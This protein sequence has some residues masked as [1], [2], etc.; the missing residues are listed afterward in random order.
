[1]SQA[2]TKLR[3][4]ELLLTAILAA[5]FGCQV[6]SPRSATKDNTSSPTISPSE[7]S[8]AVSSIE[9]LGFELLQQ[10]KPSSTGNKFISPL[11][12]Q[13]A[14]SMLA[15]GT[16]GNTLDQLQ[17]V[18]GTDSIASLTVSNQ[19]LTS[20]LRN[21]AT[22]FQLKIANAVWTSNVAQILPDYQDLLLN[23]YRAQSSSLDFSD[24]NS[25]DE[26]NNWAVT[27]TNGK[28]KKIVDH[29]DP[30]TRLILANATYFKAEW[31]R[32]FSANATA[33]ETFTSSSGQKSQ[34]PFLR[35]TTAH[36]Y[37]RGEGFQAIMRR[38]GK[39]ATAA[40]IAVRPDGDLDQFVK[41]LDSQKWESLASKLNQS[42]STYGVFKM[43]KVRIEYSADLIPNLQALGVSDAFTNS[44]NFS[45]MST[46]QLA[47]N[48]LTHKTF[49]AVDEQGTEA[50]AVTTGAVGAGIAPRIEYNMV[51]DKPYLF[52]IVHIQTGAVLFL[53]T[54]ELPEGGSMPQSNN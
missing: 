36:N 8:V 5:S 28:I 16:D 23:N 4:T 11:S 50:A 6:Q 1:M 42:T 46:E 37:I 38:Y 41:S 14:L 40:M 10:V 3:T 47:L 54:V 7:T 51:L 19:K 32:K 27:A 31:A 33:L 30:T 22:D 48:S 25:V 39:G 52:A 34:V 49:V 15:E 35:D 29:I 53:G 21:S 45:K 43:P 17:K 20:A 24:P 26:I 9:K 12:I 18:L 13:T 2:Q 44:A